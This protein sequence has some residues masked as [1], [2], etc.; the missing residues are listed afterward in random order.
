M[1]NEGDS[2][3]RQKTLFSSQGLSNFTIELQL[4]SFILEGSFYFSKNLFF[5]KNI[6]CFGRIQVILVWVFFPLLAM[7]DSLLYNIAES[8]E[9]QDHFYPLSLVKVRHFLL[10]FF[11]TPY[12]FVNNFCLVIFPGFGID[13]I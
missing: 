3:H 2:F 7:T 8:L 11:S 5:K 6:V 9:E 13:V 12:K 1:L 10:D 4:K